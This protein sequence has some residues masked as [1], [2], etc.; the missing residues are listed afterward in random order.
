MLADRS[1]PRVTVIIPAYRAMGTLVKAVQSILDQ[2]EP[3]WELLIV[4]DC[5]PDGT[6]ALADWLMSR[7]ARIGV[8]HVPQNGGK[9]RAM[10]LAMQAA[11]GRWLAVLDADDWYAPERLKTL[12]D[13][14]EATDLPLVT[15]NQVLFDF[16]ANQPV[17]TAWPMAG[18][19]SRLTLDDFL[20][21]SNPTAAFDVGM[22]KPIIRTDFLRAHA[23]EYYAPAKVGEDYLFLLGFFVSGGTALV[24]DAPLYYYVQ[25]FGSVSQEWAQAGRRRYDFSLLERI[26]AYGMTRWQHGLNPAQLAIL[27]KRGKA[28]RALAH[29]DRMRSWNRLRD[30]FRLLPHGT[31]F[32]PT[33]WGLIT[34]RVHMKLTAR[35]R[36]SEQS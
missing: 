1:Q 13:A 17:G 12:L 30:F 16:K 24:L 19:T 33:F 20:Q 3:N 11:R 31:T 2:T 22:L 6:G 32:S 4:D 14:A 29:L 26:N 5:S 35:L 23:L 27:Q 18:Q 28:I 25:P 10:N 7:D 8:M 34:R 15:D 36:P 9:P 21:R